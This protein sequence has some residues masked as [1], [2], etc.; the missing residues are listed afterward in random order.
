MLFVSVLLYWFLLWFIKFLWYIYIMY[1]CDLEGII[2][3]LF[4]GILGY[5]I[6]GE[7]V[8]FVWKV[9]LIRDI[10]RYCR[11]INYFFLR[12]G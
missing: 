3:F 7:I 8:E 1:G 6:I 2:K 11:G 4:L 5:L 9:R 12:C 10:K